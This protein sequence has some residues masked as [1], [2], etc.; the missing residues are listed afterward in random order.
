MFEKVE[1]SPLQNFI[2]ETAIRGVL[3]KKVFFKLSQYSQEDN[4]PGVSF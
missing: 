2:A 3:Q 1:N 4:C